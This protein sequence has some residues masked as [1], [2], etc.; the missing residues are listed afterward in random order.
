MDVSRPDPRRAGRAVRF[1]DDLRERLWFWP[2]LLGLLAAIAAEALVRVDR[3]LGDRDATPSWVF[4]GTAAAARSVLSTIASA[5]MTVLGVTLSITLAV[6]A[7]TGQGYSPRSI[8]RFTR[9][10][11][12]QAVIGTFV[13]TFVFAL[14]ALRMVRVDEVPGITVTVAVLLAVVALGLLI[15]FFHHMATEIQVESLIDAVWDETRSSIARTLPGRGGELP[16]APDG[17]PA[18]EVRTGRSGRIRAIDDLRLAELARTEGLTVVV[19]TA[20]G[21]FVTEGEVVAHLHGPAS[22]DHARRTRDAIAVGTRRTLTQDVAFGI[23][24]LTDIALRALS[25][26]ISDPTTAEEAILRSADLLRRISD[27]GLGECVV[28]DGRVLVLRRRPTWDD[29][30][31]RAFDQI[32][33]AAEAQAD[34]ATALVLIDALSRVVAG[35]DDPARVEAL[36]RR[37]RRVRDGARRALPE[38]SDVTRIEEATAGLA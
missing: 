32:A 5:T 2:V 30:V 25:P 14:V 35:T 10:R 9:D 18:A 31:G 6:L 26:G 15:A 12:V 17:P 4:G 1:L 27:R 8:R 34:G 36:R 29:L 33:A 7:L 21:E 19:L 23:D 20:P 11:L 24:Q 37:V 16:D 13:G 28:E 22:A 38:P 3:A